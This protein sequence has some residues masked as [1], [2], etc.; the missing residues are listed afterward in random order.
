MAETLDELLER[1]G[2]DNKEGE[3]TPEQL[4]EEQAQAKRLADEAEEKRD[5]KSVV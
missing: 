4:L 5:R 1:V 3:K 2:K